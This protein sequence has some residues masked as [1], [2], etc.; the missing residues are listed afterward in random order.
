[1][2]H[3]VDSTPLQSPAMTTQVTPTGLAAAV[4]C[5]HSR[6]N[7]KRKGTGQDKKTFTWYQLTNLKQNYTSPQRAVYLRKFQVNNGWTPIWERCSQ[8]EA[9]AF[10]KAYQGV[11]TSSTAQGGD[12]DE[13]DHIADL[14]A[15]S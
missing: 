12:T 5:G 8:D 9:K 4:P 11:T 10:Y 2:R 7:Q 14:I 15:N 1:M 3:T 6:L 13:S